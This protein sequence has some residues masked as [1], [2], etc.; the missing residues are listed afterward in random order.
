MPRGL[1]RRQEREEKSYDRSNVHP[2][3]S[4]P[5]TVF[6]YDAPDPATIQHWKDHS[7]GFSDHIRQKDGNVNREFEVDFALLQALES[8]RTLA[9]EVKIS[10]VDLAR[11]VLADLE[12]SEW[13]SQ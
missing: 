13:P 4:R 6:D 7:L 12:G 3:N 2:I 5:S 11:S 10:P 8:I 1:F 9:F